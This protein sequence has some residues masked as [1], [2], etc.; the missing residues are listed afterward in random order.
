MRLFRMTPRRWMVAVAVVAITLAAG[1]VYLRHRHFREQADFF[2]KRATD[3]EYPVALA[4]E[5][6]R[7]VSRPEDSPQWSACALEVKDHDW[8]VGLMEKYRRAARFPWLPTEPD[9]PEPK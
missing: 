9:R 5:L 2:S 8:A 6:A 3:G 4:T 1:V 7:A